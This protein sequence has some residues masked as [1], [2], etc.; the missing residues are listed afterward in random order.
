MKKFFFAMLA[1]AILTA[2]NRVAPNYEGVLMVNY[3]SNGR[4]DYSSVTGNQGTLGPGSELFQVPMYEQTADVEQITV[5]TQDGG[6]FTTDPK[7]TY[8]P[9]RGMGVDIIFN[10][11]HV[12]ATGDEAMMDNIEARVLSPLVLNAYRDV[13]RL[14]STD[15]MMFHMGQYEAQVQDTLSKVFTGKFFHLTSLTSGLVPPESMTAAIEA[16]NNA[17]IKAEQT[18]NEQEIARMELEKAKIEQETNKVKSQGLTKEILQQ[19]YIWALG[20]GNN[21][22]IVTDG[23]TPV[24]LSQ[25]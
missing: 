6:A 16:R 18:K 9:I 8:E 21:K 17:K 13:A 4:A 12:G 5:R 15:S 22:V 25:Q 20:Q 2:C 10:Y 11:K 1:V 3:G 23:R 7:Y 14:Y 19:Q 24:F